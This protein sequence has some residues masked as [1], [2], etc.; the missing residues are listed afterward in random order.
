MTIEELRARKRELMAQ[1]QNELALEASGQGDCLALF[2]VN[3]ELM[4]INAQLRA[5]APR[6]RIGARRVADGAYHADRRQYEEWAQGGEDDGGDG[7][8]SRALE[9]RE[10]V[11][12]GMSLLTGRQR[13]AFELWQGGM[14]VTEIASEL[15]VLPSTASRILGRA[16][17]VLREEAER[18]NR[19]RSWGGTVD[20]SDPFTAKVLLSAVTPKQAA[21]LYLYYSEWLSLRDIEAL[22]GVDASGVL[23]AIQRGLR[24]IGGVL[25]R[26]EAVLEHAE[27][28]DELAYGLYREMEAVDDVVPPALRPS[29]AVAARTGAGWRVVPGRLA[30]DRPPLE[31]HCQDRTELVRLRLVSRQGDRRRGRLLEALLE[32]GRALAAANRR[33]WLLRWLERVFSRLAGQFGGA[34]RW[35]LARAKREDGTKR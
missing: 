13:Q 15:G 30:G 11:Q 35:A 3:E 6:H 10:A 4:E 31:I 2:M 26:R 21:Y 22:T 34:A 18:G 27:A 9:L 8:G 20:L 33:G 14:G 32:R 25:G 1:R 5:L 28:L 23:R 12:R 17:R 16:K 7:R 19:E 24:N 29:A